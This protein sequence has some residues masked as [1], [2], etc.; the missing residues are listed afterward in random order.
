MAAGIC[1][2][3][4]YPILDKQTNR[5]ERTSMGG[6]RSMRTEFLVLYDYRTGGAWAYLLA[7]SEDQIRERFPNLQIVAQRPDWLTEDEDRR[8]RERMTIDIDDSSNP[9]IAAL[10]VEREGHRGTSTRENP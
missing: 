7:D 9:F 4:W 10:E 6:D 5:C 1:H 2:G 3:W 8:L